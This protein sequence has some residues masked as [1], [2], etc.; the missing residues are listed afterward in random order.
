MATENGR[1]RIGLALGGGVVRGFIHLG[2]LET[3]EALHIPIDYVA[4]SSA[5]AIMGAFYCAGMDLQ[6]VRQLAQQISWTNM[7][8]LSLSRDGFFSLER[9]EAWLREQLGDIY[10][11][12]LAIPFT[13]I[14]TDMDTGEAIALNQG[15]VAPAVCASCAVPGF[16]KLVELEGYRL[17]DG[18]VSNNLPIDVVR[19][20]GADTVIGVDPFRPTAKWHLGPIG[21]S[22]TAIEILVENAGGSPK[23]ADYL[24]SPELTNISYLSFAQ[25]EALINLGRKTAEGILADWSTPSEA[26]AQA[27]ATASPASSTTPSPHDAPVS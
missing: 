19:A 18:G 8:K 21:R 15:P 23:Q 12:D 4:G 9:L 17:G 7:V 20:M 25:R 16:F 26:T 27:Q 22:L 3:I 14:A 1:H 5:G 2:A 11:E 6:L 13:I 24:I 10:F